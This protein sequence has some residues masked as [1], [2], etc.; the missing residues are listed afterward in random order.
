MQACVTVYDPEGVN[1]D[2]GVQEVEAVGTFHA[3]R[4]NGLVILGSC[5][6]AIV[7]L[8]EIRGL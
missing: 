5:S 6:D 8:T 1:V 3:N 7:S 4:P 2:Q